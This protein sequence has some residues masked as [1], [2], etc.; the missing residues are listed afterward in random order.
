MASLLHIS[1]P[2]KSSSEAQHFLDEWVRSSSW[3]TSTVPM[4][5]RVIQV[6]HT[7]QERLLYLHQRNLVVNRGRGNKEAEEHLL[8]LCSHFNPGGEM[9]EEGSGAAS[10]VLKRRRDLHDEL[11]ALHTS[12]AAAEA[13]LPGQQS[14]WQAA[15]QLRRTFVE[16][17]LPSGA[18]SRTADLCVADAHR[19]SAEYGAEDLQKLDAELRS[20]MPT[21]PAGSEPAAGDA[22]EAEPEPAAPAV[23]L[24]IAEELKSVLQ[25]MVK[26]MVQVKRSSYKK[27]F[28]LNGRDLESSIHALDTQIA[29]Q[30]SQIEALERSVRFFENTFKCL[31]GDDKIECPICMEDADPKVCAITSCGHVFHDDCIRMVVDAQKHCPSCRAALVQKD[32]SLVQQVLDTRAGANVE[33]DA[34]DAP[35]HGSKMTKIVETLHHVR[36]E[37]K[38]AKIIMFCQWERILKFTAK[39]L[40][41]LGEPAP[42]VLR[43]TMAQRQSTIRDFVGSADPRHSVLLLSLEK[44]PTGMNLVSAHHLFLIHPMY[45]QNKERAVAFELQAIGR[46][47]RQGQ[48]NKVVVHRFVTQGTIEEDITQ[49]HQTHLDEVGKQQEGQRKDK[50]TSTGGISSSNISSSS[51]SSSGNGVPV[52]TADD[53]DAENTSGPSGSSEVQSALIA[54][55]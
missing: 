14:R 37:E 47:R 32:V 55:L 41:E 43:G 18:A 27:K 40:V 10:A 3:D 54:G 16:L 13:E 31:E 23:P 38:G 6:R 2:P 35:E 45:A 17:G 52:A 22:E 20:Q 21:P 12:M 8:Q 1:I 44:S 48:K 49:R 39:T 28:D 34:G 33:P 26:T 7:R 50:D 5:S 25:R 42:L 51:S 19:L 11:E 30:R 53:G 46:L 9:D 24:V 36:K 4:E 15:G 29:R